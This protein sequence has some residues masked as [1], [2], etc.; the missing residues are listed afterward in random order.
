MIRYLKLV[1]MELS[2]FGKFLAGLLVLVVLLQFGSVV[3]SSISY[4]NSQELQRET[5]GLSQQEFL[6][7]EG[8]W[9]AS[10]QDMMTAGVLFNGSILLVA[11]FLFLYIFFIWYRDWLGKNTF[12]YR[13]LMLPTDRVHVY[14]AKLT[15]IVLLVLA[16]LA[17]QLLLLPLEKLVFEMLIP[18]ELRISTSIF[19]V[20][21][22]VY[23][24]N[25]ILPL[26]ALDFLIY[27]G[28]GLTVVIL[29]FTGI[30]IE[31]SY[32]LKGL[33][34]GLIFVAIAAALILSPMVIAFMRWF[35]F[36][37]WEVVWL[38]IGVIIIVTLISLAISF[39]LIRYKVTV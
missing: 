21:R 19:E 22:G 8:F 29:I 27:Y 26:Q 39:R 32:R 31:R 24:F 13:M 9:P 3:Y 20:I 16:F 14:L 5:M 7:R 30:V 17:L 25:Y 12:I 36:Y 28:A 11:G 2:R 35:E 15:T 18:E 37:I 33:I 23:L 34:G 6:N 10:L 1:H 4:K 38:E